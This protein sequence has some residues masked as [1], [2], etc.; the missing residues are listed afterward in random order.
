MVLGSSTFAAN[1]WER[2]IE[3]ARPVY[4]VPYLLGNKISNN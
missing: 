4:S 3:L 2:A 1:R